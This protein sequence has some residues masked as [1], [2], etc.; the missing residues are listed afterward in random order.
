MRIEKCLDK[1]PMDLYEKC[2]YAS[3]TGVPEVFVSGRW[4]PLADYAVSKLHGPSADSG[5]GQGCDMTT[6]PGG[7]VRGDAVSEDVDICEKAAAR[8]GKT[9]VTHRFVRDYFQKSKSGESNEP[10]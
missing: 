2:V 3:G 1:P 8:D 9:R 10:T 7:G 5:T 4:R 6:G